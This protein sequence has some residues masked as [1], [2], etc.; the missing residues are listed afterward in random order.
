[1]SPD[2]CKGAWRFDTLWELPT[3]KF[4]STAF[5]DTDR[6]NILDESE[7]AFKRDA[8]ERTTFLMDT[9]SVEIKYKL[10]DLERES[11]TSPNIQSKVYS[12]TATKEN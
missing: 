7:T 2:A 5:T 8:V 4:G 12:V 10:S 9:I 6:S 3:H 1:M 11:N